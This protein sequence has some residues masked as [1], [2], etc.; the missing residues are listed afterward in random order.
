MGTEPVIKPVRVRTALTAAALS[1]ALVGGASMASLAN[2]DPAGATSAPSS[3][4]SF[5]EIVSGRI[6]APFGKTFDPFRDGTTRVHRGIDIGAPIGTPIR[7]P[8]DGTILAATDL[9][10][11]Q[12]AYGKVIVI[13]TASQ[14]QTLFSHLDDYAVSEGQQVRKGEIIGTVGNTGKSTGPHVHIETFIEGER[15]DPMEVWGPIAQ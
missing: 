9:Y 12:P 1:M 5:G 10:Q 6:T 13:A 15:V 3:T 2:A 14:T 7:A 11:D 8:A 4:V